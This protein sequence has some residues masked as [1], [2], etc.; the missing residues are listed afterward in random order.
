MILR[1]QILRS[2]CVNSLIAS[3]DCGLFNI[4]FPAGGVKN[5]S[6]GLRKPVLATSQ[7]AAQIV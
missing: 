1:S 6:R 3:K 7:L 5:K 2:V 4:K